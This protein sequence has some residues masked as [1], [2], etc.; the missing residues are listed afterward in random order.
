MQTVILTGIQSEISMVI[1]VIHS[2]TDEN[3][4]FNGKENKEIENIQ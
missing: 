2:K 4:N 3:L 1:I